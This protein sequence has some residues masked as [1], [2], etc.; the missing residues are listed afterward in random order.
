MCS[1]HPLSVDIHTHILLCL[2]IDYL[3]NRKQCVVFN[4]TISRFFDIHTGVPQGSSL[5]PLLFLIYINDLPFLTKEVNIL[6]YADD[7]T[8]YGIREDFTLFESDINN[9]LDTLNN[10]FKLNKLSLNAEKTKLMIY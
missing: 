2:L 1:T 9:I 4:D 7:T 8:L 3:S 6:M 5:G 10:W